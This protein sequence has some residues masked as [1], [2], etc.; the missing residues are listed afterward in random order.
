MKYYFIYIIIIILY[1]LYIYH[2]NKLIKGWAHIFLTGTRKYKH[3]D[4][5][6]ELKYNIWYIKY[7][8]LDYINIQ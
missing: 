6:M 4:I 8:W 1:I 5:F 2:L 7:M 3:V